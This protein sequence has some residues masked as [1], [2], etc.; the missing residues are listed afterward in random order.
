MG[1]PDPLN[2]RSSYLLHMF[3]TMNLNWICLDWQAYLHLQSHLKALGIAREVIGQN[4]IF[5]G[6]QRRKD[7]L[8]FMSKNLLDEFWL[9]E[10]DWMPL[11]LRIPAKLKQAI[12]TC[13][14]D[15]LAQY[16]SCNLRGL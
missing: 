13:K 10:D 11:D 6:C 9:R 4:Y 8:Y 15:R 16:S 1:H 5:N 2:I 7:G 3:D 12:R 14:R